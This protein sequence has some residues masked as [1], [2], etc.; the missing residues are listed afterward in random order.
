M[1]IIQAQRG[2]YTF[3]KRKECEKE[4]ERGRG[5]GGG[6]C[7]LQNF[8]FAGFSA[9]FLTIRGMLV[10]LSW[11]PP[12]YT[13]GNVLIRKLSIK[14]CKK[15]QNNTPIKVAKFSFLSQKMRKFFRK[16]FLGNFFYIRIF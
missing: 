13:T 9:I 14:P 15:V 5:G 12:I 2:V 11:P 8:F 3:F 6:L 16:S 1:C 10:V 7:R 4:R